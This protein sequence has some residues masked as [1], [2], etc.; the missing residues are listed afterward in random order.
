MRQTL[1]VFVNERSLSAACS[2]N[3]LLSGQAHEEASF[4]KRDQQSWKKQPVVS[5][6]TAYSVL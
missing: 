6:I 4:C 2:K 1:V 5:C 3:R